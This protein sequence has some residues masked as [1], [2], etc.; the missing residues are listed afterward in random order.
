LEEL[1]NAGYKVY[2]KLL[3]SADFGVAQRRQRVYI[4]GIR[5]DIPHTPIDWDIATHKKATLQESFDDLHGEPVDIYGKSWQG[6]LHSNYNAGEFDE[7]ILLSEDYL[8]L[9][10]RNQQLRIYRDTTPT[11]IRGNTG[12]FYVFERKLYRINGYQA[13]LLQGFPQEFVKKA[14]EAK[15]NPRKL[16]MQ[17]GNAMTVTVIEAICGSLLRSISADKT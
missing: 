13:L 14:K 10:R 17:A 7:E 2:W 5:A 12:L 16:L 3:N 15:I 6:Y 8:I 1:K 11:I 4:V 9:D